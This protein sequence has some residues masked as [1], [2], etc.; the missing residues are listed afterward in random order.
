MKRVG[1]G[2]GN[3]VDDRAGSAPIFRAVVV[4]LNAELLER[5]RI[6]EWIVDVGVMIDITSAVEMVVDA[7][8][9]GTARRDRLRAGVAS[10]LN[11]VAAAAGI[12]G[13]QI[14]RA[15]RE[16]NQC[17]CVASVQ[18]EIDNLPLPDYLAQCGRSGL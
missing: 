16:Q 7:I 8:A 11:G 15:G 18:R 1:A 3:D 14:G 9:A 10:T 6:G 13:V 12:P 2:F 17:R 4:G 5:V